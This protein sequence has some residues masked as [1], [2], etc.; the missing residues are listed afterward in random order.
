MQNYKTDV[1]IIDEAPKM[2][3]T[4]CMHGYG[5][6]MDGTYLNCEMQFWD[7]EEILWIDMALVDDL[8]HSHRRLDDISN[9]NGLKKLQSRL[10]EALEKVCDTDKDSLWFMWDKQDT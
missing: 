7:P 3:V 2:A 8:F 6:E 1:Q 5:E 4:Y 10:N 9:I